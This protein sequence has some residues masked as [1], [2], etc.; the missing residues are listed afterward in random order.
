MG[1]LVDRIYGHLPLGLQNAAVS[2]YGWRW[3]RRRYGGVFAEELRRF[4]EREAYTREQWHDYQTTELRR[5]LVH[6]FETVPFYHRVYSS[7]GF[8]IDELRNFDLKDLRRLPLLS[9]NDL[10]QYGRSDLLSSKPEARGEF[11]ASSGSTGT[12]TSI[13]FSE[14]F[15]QRWS[16]AFE[17]RIRH[18]AGLD[19][20]MARG[21]IGGRRVVRSA[22][23]P[24]PYYRHNVFEKQTYFSAYHIAPDSADDYLE[25]IRRHGVEYMTGY[26]MSNFLLA[27]MFDD[28]SLQAP[29]L[30]AVVVSSEKL[31]PHMREVFARVYNCATYDSYSGVEACGLIS[32]NAS[33]ELMWSPDVAVL[34]VL[35]SE[36]NEVGPGEEG[37]L[38]CTG[39]LNFDQPLI[40]YRIGDTVTLAPS[41]A[42]ELGLEMPIIGEIGG[43]I[44]DVIVGP[45]G[46]EMVRFHGVFIDLPG[47]VAAQV[48]QEERDSIRVNVIA[49]PEFGE[50]E[51]K[52]IAERLRSQLGDIN[53]SIDKVTELSRNASGKIPAV[54]SRLEA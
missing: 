54:I 41:Q 23:A 35:D 24:P 14:A 6:A 19:R 25:G 51:E 4:K 49:E 12:P 10:R 37:E 36:G 18:W 8:G 3:K 33:G 21:M 17:A 2:L 50:P 9:K 40:R 53:V 29:E 31:T 15:H 11:F 42:S 30:R 13:L 32:E 27:R 38:V 48:V 52:L 46:R 26:A 43:R 20:S 5:L 22:T 44:E 39:L 28:L 45:D 1:G 7:A 16:A 34:E 47:L